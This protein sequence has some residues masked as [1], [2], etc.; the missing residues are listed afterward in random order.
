MRGKGNA[1]A[2]DVAVLDDG[3]RVRLVASTARGRSAGAVAV[4]SRASRLPATA[5]RVRGV[6]GVR[7]RRVR[8]ATWVYVVRAGRVRA[9]GTASRSLARSRAQ[10]RSAA[11]SLRTARATNAPR[12]YSPS[13]AETASGGALTG[14]TLAGSTNPSIDSTLALLCRLQVSAR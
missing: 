14:R 7:I 5:R 3:G 6:A 9:V 2:A 13:E 11:R 1:R 12:V 10:L 4:G 8:R